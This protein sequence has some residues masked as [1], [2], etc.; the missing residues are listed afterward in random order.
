MRG[1]GRLLIVL[2]VIL[3]LVAAGGVLYV[4]M[5]GAQPPPT[6]PSP[7]V[8]VPTTQIIVAAQNI[9][10][11]SEISED[12]VTRRDWPAGSEP[13]DVIADEAELIGKVAKTDIF[14]GQP[15]LRSMLTEIVQ[16]SDAAFAIPEGKVAVAFP[17]TRFS[18]VGYGI[19]AGDHVDVL[20][21]AR[22]IDREEE[23]QSA[24]DTVDFRVE[25]MGRLA[26]ANVESASFDIPIFGAKARPVTQLI[27][28]NAGI[29]KVGS[30]ATP[31]PPPV[32]EGEEAAA[33]P[34][35]APP[36]MVILVVS[37]QDALVLKYARENNFILDLA[38]RAAGDE[39][40]VTTEAITLE[41]MIRRFNISFPPQ[42]QYY[43]DTV[44]PV[45]EFAPEKPE[46]PQETSIETTPLEVEIPTAGGTTP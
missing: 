46:F 30:W 4:M 7:E 28:Q 33:P 40:P 19:Q 5:Q 8:T 38:L 39:T 44:P 41:Y 14:Q 16:G 15:I 43:L 3:G 36:D 37:Q 23:K 10:R 31:T 45:E 22:F 34:A 35:A 20:L 12:T 2:G 25:V 11:G 17:I 21:S 9:P 29:L 18:S 6:T 24:R 13:P 26:A 27:V 32:E 42:L 1:R